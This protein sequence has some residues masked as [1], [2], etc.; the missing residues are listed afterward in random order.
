MKPNLFF[1]HRLALLAIVT[2]FS[3]AQ[4]DEPKMRDVATHDELAQRLRMF[5][6][7]DPIKDIGP[8]VG[9][10]E[11]DPSVTNAPKGFIENSTAL[12][13]RGMMTFVPKQAVLNI[14][15]GMEERTEIKKGAKILTFQ[16][17]LAANRGWIRTMEVSR[18]QALGHA[19]FPEGQ[20]EAV[21]ESSS[22]VIA[23]YRAGP[24]S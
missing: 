16:K 20:M 12:S 10:T 13:F 1:P 15:E 2:L 18:E 14:P 11:E 8:P 3:A 19:E 21:K 24:I 7:N 4:A 9:K 6:Q 17:F 5:Q 22:V 23:T